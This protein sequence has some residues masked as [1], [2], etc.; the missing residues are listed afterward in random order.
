[1]VLRGSNMRITKSLGSKTSGGHTV[2]TFEV[3]LVK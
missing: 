1:M 3:E 2:H